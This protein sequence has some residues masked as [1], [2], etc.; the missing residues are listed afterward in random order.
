VLSGRNG[1]AQTMTKAELV[2]EVS[3]VS[4]LTKKHSEVIVDS[5]FQTIIDALHR[6]E[7]IELRGFGS[8]R[9]R[10]REPRKGR[11]PK[12][13]DKVDVP[14]KKV[15]YFKPGKELKDLINQTPAPV[16]SGSA[17]QTSPD[18]ERGA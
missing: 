15:P 16:D 2:E 9:L 17:D 3:R 10:Q 1:L 5:V 18:G 11:N 14:P 4:D 7:K 8:F 13:G 6:G 12:T